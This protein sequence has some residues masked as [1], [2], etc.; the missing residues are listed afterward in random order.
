MYSGGISYERL[1]EMYHAV[2]AAQ[3]VY[4]HRTS[5]RGQSLD[6]SL[7]SPWNMECHLHP[8]RPLI[9][10][11]PSPARQRFFCSPD[12]R[13]LATPKPWQ[14]APNA[15]EYSINM[16]ECSFKFPLGLW[17]EAD[18][19]FGRHVSIEGYAFWIV[20]QFATHSELPSLCTLRK[21]HYKQNCCRS[22]AI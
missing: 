14:P 13:L 10:T 7:G 2:R 18:F 21:H 16:E 17:G 12:L 22:S 8:I 5:I 20:H 19:P 1:R 4:N 15:V 3:E 9:F 11:T 6:S